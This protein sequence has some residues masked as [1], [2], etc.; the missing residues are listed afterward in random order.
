M[1][2]QSHFWVYTRTK[3]NQYLEETICTPMV[4]AAYFTI[5][6]NRNYLSI[7]QQDWIQKMQWVCTYVHIYMMEYSALEKEGNPLIRDNMDE[8][9]EHNA[10]W[11]KP[12]LGQIA[13]A[14]TYMGNL[15]KKKKFIE[16]RI[17]VARGCRVGKIEMLVKEY[18][19]TVIQWIRYVNYYSIY[20]YIYYI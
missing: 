9:G 14:V 2:Q 12:D 10:K 15:K 13:H 3:G 19:F 8:A 6:R 4:T 20:I 5:A 16:S 18:K 7:H 1:I 17:M 11:N